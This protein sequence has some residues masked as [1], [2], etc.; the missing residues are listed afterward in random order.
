MERIYYLLVKNGA[1]TINQVP[2]HLRNAV[3]ALLDA[4]MGQ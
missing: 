3:Q 2:V 1:R 4:D